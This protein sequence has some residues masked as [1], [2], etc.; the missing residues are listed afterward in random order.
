VILLL[1]LM[2]ASYRLDE[3]YKGPP[4]ALARDII[5]AHSTAEVQAKIKAFWDQYLS[6]PDAE[7]SWIQLDLIE[8]RKPKGFSEAAKAG[9]LGLN[10]WLTKKIKSTKLKAIPA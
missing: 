3:S 4:G 2:P 1:S 10:V 5:L 8:G 7:P 6:R 9:N